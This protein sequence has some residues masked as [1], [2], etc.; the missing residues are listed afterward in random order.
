MK[1]YLH[2]GTEKT[3]TSTLQEFFHLNR[4]EFL[5]DGLIYTKRAG[6]K[7]N[8]KLSVAAYNLDKRDDFTKNVGISSNNQLREFQ[9]KTLNAIRQEI[10]NLNSSNSNLGIIFSSE[11][12]QSRLLSLEEIKRLKDILTS[13]GIDEYVVI[14][15]LRNPVLLANSLYSTSVKAGSVL[16]QPPSPDNSYYQNICNHK[17]TIQKFASVFGESA[18]CP[19]IF[20]ESEFKNGSIIQD[21]LEI[22]NLSVDSNYKIP[23]NKNLSLSHLNLQILRRINKLIPS[24]IDD[25]PNPVRANIVSFFQ[26]H[27]SEIK[28]VMPSAIAEQYEKAFK[29]SNQWVRN[30]YFP[31]RKNLFS[32]VDLNSVKKLKLDNKELDDIAL[33]ISKIWTQKEN[34]IVALEHQSKPKNIL[35]K[36][37]G[38]LFS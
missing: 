8:R 19:K 3:A 7:N 33:L 22:L 21:F 28:Y 30:T 34:Q 18:I 13:F 20:D 38:K 11:H 25:Q 32:P 17:N 37:M 1:C 31:D 23:D 5:K 14:V 4:T 24:Y 36:L 12:F 2:I 6:I 10:K 27:E 9:K 26:S 16:E 15:Y 29:A 35:K